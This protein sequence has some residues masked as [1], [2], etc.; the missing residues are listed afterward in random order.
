MMTDRWTW[1]VVHYEKE[2]GVCPVREF[3]DELDRKDRQ[4]VLAAIDLLGEEG[5]NLRR[6]YA[7]TLADGIHELRV[8]VSTLQYRVLY[9]FFDRRDIVLTNGFR[10]TGARVPKQEIQRA[11]A[12]RDDW[13]GRQDEDAQTVSQ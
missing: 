10:K 7:D 9:F 5:P 8:R 11:C 2:D 4:K 6:P 3:L 1:R 12:Y 13:L